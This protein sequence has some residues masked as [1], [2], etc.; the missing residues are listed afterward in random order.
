MHF[1]AAAQRRTGSRSR[2]TSPSSARPITR[3]SSEHPEWFRHRPDGTIQYAEN[4]PKKYQDI[5]PFDFEMRRRGATL[6]HA[7]RDVLRFWIEHGVRIFRVDNPHTKPF[8]VLGV[9]DRRGPARIPDVIFLAEAFTR[10]K[11]MQRLA[12]I[13]F[14][15]SYTYFTWRNTRGSSSEYLTELTQTELVDYFRPNF[16]ANTPD[17]LHEYLQ[18]GGPPAFRIR[19]VLAATPGAVLRHLQ[20]L[21]ALRERAAVRDG[22]RGIPRLGE[23]PAPASRLVESGVARSV[24][25]AA[26]RDPS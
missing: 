19:A 9:G 25:H 8:R 1:V 17:I 11:V 21:R 4:P 13:G 15:Q 20:R 26:Q 6:W 24:H 12:K 7:L 18:H 16:L 2:S 14:T 23:V 3:G 10:P 22:Q 5:Y